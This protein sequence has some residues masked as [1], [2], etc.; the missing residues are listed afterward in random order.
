MFHQVRPVVQLTGAEPLDVPLA[1]KV[2]QFRFNQ[3]ALEGIALIR[4]QDLGEAI[5]PFCRKACRIRAA[6]QIQRVVFVGG[7]CQ[8][9][10]PVA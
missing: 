6:D 9:F 10:H 2:E 4:L 3:F 1:E 8:L 5:K 7:E